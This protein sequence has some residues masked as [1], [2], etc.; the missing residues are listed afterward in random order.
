MGQVLLWGRTWGMTGS[1]QLGFQCQ[2]LSRPHAIMSSHFFL[3][4]CKEVS[5][6]QGGWGVHTGP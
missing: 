3:P 2:T 1:P 5:G 6:G 4:L